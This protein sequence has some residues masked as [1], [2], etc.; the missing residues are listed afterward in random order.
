MGEDEMRPGS[1]IRLCVQNPSP[2]DVPPS[3]SPFKSPRS[4]YSPCP[5]PNMKTPSDDSDSSDCDPDL[6]SSPKTGKCY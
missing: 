2:R 3:Q 6:S 5:R 1:H 4:L